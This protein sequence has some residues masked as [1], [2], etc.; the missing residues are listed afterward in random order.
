MGEVAKEL[1]QDD[2]GRLGE[3]E[4]G[5]HCGRENSR[6]NAREREEKGRE[7]GGTRLEEERGVDQIKKRGGKGVKRLEEMSGKVREREM[8]GGLMRKRTGR[9]GK[10]GGGERQ[11]RGRSDMQ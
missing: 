1:E 2:E 5:T 9:E 4:A 6:R 11:K 10:Q 3:W 7:E 8:L